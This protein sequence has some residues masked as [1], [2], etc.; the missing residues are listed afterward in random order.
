MLLKEK[1]RARNVVTCGGAKIDRHPAGRVMSRH[2]RSSRK[3]CR[4]EARKEQSKQLLQVG[5]LA[6]GGVG[7]VLAVS[8][9]RFSATA[10]AV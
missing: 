1:H 8:Q 10:V 5:G 3:P 2:C 4:L 7:Y 9:R 6:A